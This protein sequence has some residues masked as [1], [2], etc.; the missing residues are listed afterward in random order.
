MSL[1][2]M[3][4]NCLIERQHAPGDIE[5]VVEKALSTKLPKLVNTAA[6]QRILILVT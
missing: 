3:P 2:G 4:G 1:A 5:K 6:D